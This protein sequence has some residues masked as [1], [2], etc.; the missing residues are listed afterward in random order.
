MPR[1]YDV[2]NPDNV[3]QGDY[4]PCEAPPIDYRV[5]LIHTIVTCPVH[6]ET[7]AQ[8]N[9]LLKQIAGNRYL[10]GKLND[11]NIELYKY[12]KEYGELEDKPRVQEF[13]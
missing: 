5:E 10:Q 13:E 2:T 9:S 12:K 7:L 3:T 1:D 11:A 8:V 6:N 4:D